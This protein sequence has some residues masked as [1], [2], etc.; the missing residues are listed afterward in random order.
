[1]VSL[2][3]IE[4]KFLLSLVS[5]DDYRSKITKVKPNSGTPASERNKTCE[6]LVSRGYV[7]CDR[8]ISKFAIAGPGKELLKNADNLPV[9]LDEREQK[10]LESCSQAITPG[11]LGKKVPADERQPLLRNLVDRG[12]IK[13]SQESIKDVWLSAQ[14]KQF[15]QEEYV[16]EGNWGVTATKVGAYIKFLRESASRPSTQKL[17]TGQPKGQQPLSQPGSLPNSAMP[18]GSQ[19]KPD[20]QAVLQQIKQLDRLLGTENYLPIFHLRDK[21]QPPLTREELDSILYRLQREDLIEL[22]S[23]HNQGKYSDQQLADGIK[24]EKGN[25]LFFINVV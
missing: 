15:L 18:I 5:F 24:Q 14:G 21:L 16:P 2:K 1:M 11:T 10:V 12:L 6:S 19:S 22:S 20:K 8:E 25:Y 13:A 23:L 4:L 17:P 7:E 9:K 3:A